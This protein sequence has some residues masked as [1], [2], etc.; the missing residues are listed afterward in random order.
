[1]TWSPIAE[2]SVEELLLTTEFVQEV[3][4]INAN[5][6]GLNDTFTVDVSTATE[7]RKKLTVKF[8]T[9]TPSARFSGEAAALSVLQSSPNIPTPKLLFFSA[10][11]DVKHVYEPVIVTTHSSETPAIQSKKSWSEEEYLNFLKKAGQLLGQLHQQTPAPCFGEL[12]LKYSRLTTLERGDDWVT[13]FTERAERVFNE[14]AQQFRQLSSEV[15]RTISMLE[16]YLAESSECQLLHLDYWW[17]NIGVDSNNT[18]SEV[19]NW[20]RAMGGDPLLNIATAEFMLIENDSFPGVPDERSRREFRRGYK[21]I[22]PLTWSWGIRERW[23]AY[24]L[25]AR[26][27]AL[28]GFPYWYRNQSPSERAGIATQL[29]RDI[30]Y[31]CDGYIIGAPL[32]E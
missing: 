17:G 7:S 29:R 27:R 12:C 26:F 16:P 6:K 19:W 24:Q 5:H 15:P 21:S 30:Q 2:Q 25:Y 23:R 28:R 3:K 9:N 14:R 32:S 11:P 22:R 13:V 20:W 1:V 10:K 31:L 8:G 4:S 18:P